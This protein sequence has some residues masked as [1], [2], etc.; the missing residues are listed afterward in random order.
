M[1]GLVP[2]TSFPF[3]NK[4][5]ISAVFLVSATCWAIPHRVSLYSSFR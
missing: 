2:S 5:V 4:G 1:L 3:E